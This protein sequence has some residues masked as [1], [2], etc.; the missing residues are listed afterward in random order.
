MSRSRSGCASRRARPARP[1][2]RRADR[3]LEQRGEPALDARA[4]RSSSS[5]VRSGATKARSP[6]SAST[7]P[8]QSA[9]AASRSP[10]RRRAARSARAS[11]SS[12]STSTHVATAR[13]CA[14]ALR[15]STLRSSDTYFCSVLCA[16]AGGRPSQTSSMSRST[17]TT[18][19]AS[20]S[21]R[22]STARWRRPPS[23]TGSPSRTTS[24]GPRIER[25]ASHRLPP[26]AYEFY[27]FTTIV[28]PGRD[29]A[30]R[31][32]RETRRRST[33]ENPRSDAQHS[34]LLAARRRGTRLHGRDHRGDP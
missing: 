2:P 13:R 14:G 25:T 5:R 15:R 8:R 16:V 19:P 27:R 22:A 26:R 28:L 1:R 30:A 9:S 12:A 33:K 34:E 31:R 7:S 3:R 29:R 23:G 10:A 11:S 32:R 6:T 18:R 4:R 24:N 21:N 17:G 20:T